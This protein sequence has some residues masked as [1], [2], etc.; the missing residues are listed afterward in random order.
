MLELIHFLQLLAI[1]VNISTAVVCSLYHDLAL[2]CA[3]LHAII[4]CPSYMFISEV[5]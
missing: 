5:L 4:P 3:H 1:Y 2:L